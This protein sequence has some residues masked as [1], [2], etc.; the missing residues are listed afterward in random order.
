MH[1]RLF[2]IIDYEIFPIAHKTLKVFRESHSL[3]MD[4]D[5]ILRLFSNLRWHD[6]VRKFLLQVRRDV[7]VCG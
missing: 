7:D 1:V 4:E 6:P 3:D 2:P 5:D